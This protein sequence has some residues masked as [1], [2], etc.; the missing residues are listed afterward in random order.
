VDWSHH[1]YVVLI[2]LPHGAPV[3]AC[4]AVLC[5]QV[6][7]RAMSTSVWMVFGPVDLAHS[8][9]LPFH[10]RHLKKTNR[11]TLNPLMLGG[12]VAGV[13]PL[14]GLQDLSDPQRCCH[15]G[16]QLRNSLSQTRS[17]IHLGTGTWLS[18]GH[19]LQTA[20]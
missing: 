7:Q 6:G 14:A 9:K 1:L 5:G 4:T 20:Y 3:K 17:H 13:T 10:Q 18:Y 16:P 2:V 11:W 8:E 15:S 19:S 12:L